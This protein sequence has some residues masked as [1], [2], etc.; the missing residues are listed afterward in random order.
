MN[1]REMIENVNSE[2][3]L[4]RFLRTEPPKKILALAVRYPSGR[5]EAYKVD[6]FFLGQDRSLVLQGDLRLTKYTDRLE[7]VQDNYK[8]K[9]LMPREL[10][11][12]E[13]YYV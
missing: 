5:I 1:L 4:K 8:I 12:S 6:K 2:S 9:T 7:P 13:I 10:D 11:R 3:T